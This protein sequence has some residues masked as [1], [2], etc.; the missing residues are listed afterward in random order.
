M[1][2]NLKWVREREGGE[3]ERTREQESER[4]ERAY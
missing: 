3:R 4:R 1:Q 2:L